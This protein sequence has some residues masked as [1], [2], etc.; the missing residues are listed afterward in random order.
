MCAACGKEIEVGGSE[1]FTCNNE[2][3]SVE[4]DP[5]TGEQ[6]TVPCPR[7]GKH[8]HRDAKV[9]EFVSPQ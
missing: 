1:T 8:L 4:V 9:T 5:E 7:F 2:A 6:R 3:A